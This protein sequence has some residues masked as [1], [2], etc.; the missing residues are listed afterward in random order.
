[1]KST[2]IETPAQASRRTTTYWFAAIGIFVSA[3]SII[4]LIVR[5]FDVGLAPV[6]FDFVEFYRSLI[7]PIYGLL[8][9]LPISIPAWV[10]DIIVLYIAIYS[11]DYRTRT[12]I[13]Q[14][15]HMIGGRSE[16]GLFRKILHSIRFGNIRMLIGLTKLTRRARSDPRFRAALEDE[17]HPEHE[18]AKQLHGFHE[19]TRGGVSFL[20][21]LLVGLIGAVVVF[22]AINAYAPV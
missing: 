8:D 16:F 21:F 2:H 7:W 9:Y 22:F 18:K 17:S 3:S 12:F 20:L 11:I 10:G 15:T 19:F 14:T 13:D 5:V 4:S 6:L 1:M